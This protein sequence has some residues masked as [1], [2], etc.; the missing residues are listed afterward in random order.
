M[1]RRL[2]GEPWPPVSSPKGGTL[3]LKQQG[4]PPAGFEPE[5]AA[6]LCGVQEA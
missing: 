4:V 5:L 2:G 3:T 6:W 1:H